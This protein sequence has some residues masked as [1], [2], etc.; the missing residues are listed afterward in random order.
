MSAD[1]KKIQSGQRVRARAQHLDNHHMLNKIWA[2]THTYTYTDENG[3]KETARG[4]RHTHLVLQKWHMSVITAKTLLSIR[5]STTTCWLPIPCTSIPTSSSW[6][7]PGCHIVLV[8]RV[9]SPPGFRAA[10]ALSVITNYNVWA[11]AASSAT[12]CVCVC[13]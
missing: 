6:P 12:V 1:V 4:C 2:H 13:A 3:A 8:E 7:R 9:A 10:A 5:Q 11:I